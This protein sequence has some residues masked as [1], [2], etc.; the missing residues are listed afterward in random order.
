MLKTFSNLHSNGVQ[1]SHCFEHVNAMKSRVWK[2]LTLAVALLILL[3][4]GIDQSFVSYSNNFNTTGY[5]ANGTVIVVAVESNIMV[6]GELTVQYLGLAV[7]PPHV[8]LPNGTVYTVYSS[9]KINFHSGPTIFS[10][11]SGEVGGPANLSVS[12]SK[13]VDAGIISDVPASYL[14]TTIDIYKTSEIY[15]FA[16]FVQNFSAVQIV[17]VG[18][19]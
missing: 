16:I 1:A 19:F 3:I 9:L 13:P 5:G 4:L 10:G 17:A 11:Q 12:S 18:G 14:N 7:G 2:F 6:H 15:C 8:I